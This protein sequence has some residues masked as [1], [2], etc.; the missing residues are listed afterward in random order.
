MKFITLIAAAL[1][2][3]SVAAQSHVD[4]YNDSLI[5]SH[6]LV[7]LDGKPAPEEVGA[8]V[9]SVR[10]VIGKFYY[11]QFP[12]FS[13]PTGPVFSF[14]EQGCRPRHGHRW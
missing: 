4:T 11:D 6:R 3:L 12:S 5:A 8:Y 1:T 13:G 9:D 14:S 7:W 10:R 2:A